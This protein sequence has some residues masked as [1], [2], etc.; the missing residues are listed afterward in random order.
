MNDFSEEQL[1]K[2]LETPLSSQDIMKICQHKA[3]LYLYNQ[4]GQFNTIEKLLG[5]H[6][7][8]IL[9]YEWKPSFG[10][11]VCVF[12]SIPGKRI[13]F[14][15]P[16]GYKPDDEKKFIPANMWKFPFLSWLLK[17]AAFD[18]WEVEYNNYQFQKRKYEDVNTCGRWV[19]VRLLLRD[20]PLE[21]FKEIFYNKDGIASDLLVTAFTKLIIE[22]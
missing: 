5:K 14:F 9:L 19:G 10:H 4:I 20:F 3:N 1:E 12:E 22:K 11:W 15:D 18:G 13:E 2:D 17:E 8:T 21:E 7:A 6:K 16:Y